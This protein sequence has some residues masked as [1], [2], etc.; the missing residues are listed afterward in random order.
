MCAPSL[1]ITADSPD[2][3]TNKQVEDALDAH[4]SP[5]LGVSEPHTPNQVLAVSQK[6]RNDRKGLH[7]VSPLSLTHTVEEIHVEEYDEEE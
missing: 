2:A 6:L 7:S 3:P 4:L 1:P 5:S